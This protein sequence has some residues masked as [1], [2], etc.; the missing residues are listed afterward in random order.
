[1]ETY[2]LYHQSTLAIDS[3]PTRWGHY[4]NGNLEAPK[5]PQAPIVWCPH[6]LGTLFEWKLVYVSYKSKGF[7]KSPLA[8]DII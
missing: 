4:L 1:M 5:Y 6:S 2:L 7:G 8:G 3:V